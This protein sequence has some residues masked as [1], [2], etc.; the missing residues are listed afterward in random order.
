[1]RVEVKPFGVE[2]RQRRF[3]RAPIA[4]RLLRT[5]ERE[6]RVGAQIVGKLGRRRLLKEGPSLADLPTFS[7]QHAN[8]GIEERVG[9]QHGVG[10]PSRID[11]SVGN[12][13]RGLEVGARDG[14]AVGGDVGA[15]ERRGCR[16]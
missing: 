1:M 10:G 13:A 15:R 3:G 9:P 11:Q 6:E 12:P 14:G 8:H 2:Q 5:R 4:H 7:Q 16:C